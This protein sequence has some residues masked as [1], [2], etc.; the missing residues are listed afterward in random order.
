MTNVDRY[1]RW[2]QYEKDSHAKVV[3]SLR[4]VP[5]EL[6]TQ[7]AFQKAVDLLAHMAAARGLWLFRLG[8][9]S[10][11]VTDIFP[12]GVDLDETARK[13]EEIEGIWERYLL[14]LRD[15]DLAEYFKYQS[16]EGPRFRNTI[17]DI[18]AQL[19]GHSWYHRGQ[20]AALVR[21]LGCE[22]AVTDLIFWTREPV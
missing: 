21:S 5:A 22:P 14:L 10:E 15:S 11:P 9:L 1:S 13:L 8:G 6:R 19:F 17:E 20:I 2:F 12:T 3:A 7:P 16:L 4:N 18:L